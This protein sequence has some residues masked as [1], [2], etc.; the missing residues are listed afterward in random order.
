MTLW[1]RGEGRELN[2]LGSVESE[3]VLGFYGGDYV[4]REHELDT[5]DEDDAGQGFTG[6]VSFKQLDGGNVFLEKRLRGVGLVYEAD[7]PLEVSVERDY[8]A[9]AD[10][11]DTVPATDGIAIENLKAA[12]TRGK[13]FRVTLT[14]DRP[15]RL[16]GWAAD[17]QAEGQGGED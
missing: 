2:V 13:A 8:G 17:L 11:A 6:S 5:A 9:Q 1:S 4:G 3:G 12:R 7:E 10:L 15:W 16:Y 14:G